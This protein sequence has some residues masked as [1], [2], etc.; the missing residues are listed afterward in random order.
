MAAQKTCL[1]KKVGLAVVNN[2][3]TVRLLSGVNSGLGKAA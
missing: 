1:P 2:D 3:V